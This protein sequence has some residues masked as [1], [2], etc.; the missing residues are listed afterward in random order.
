[1]NKT[2]K[3]IRWLQVAR[4]LTIITLLATSMKMVAATVEYPQVASN[5]PYS[6]VSALRHRS[7]DEKMQYGDDPLQYAL[8][9]KAKSR[10]VDSGKP[11]V[12]LIHG[13]CWLNAFDI[14]HTFPLSTGLTQH[15]YDVWSLEYRRTGDK[16][17]GWPGT[18]NDIKLGVL[19]ATQYTGHENLNNTVVLGHSAGGHLALLAGS[20]IPDLKGV[21]GLAAIADI[22]QYSRGKNS[23][24]SVTKDFMQGTAD[25]KPDAYALANPVQQKPHAKVRLL[26]GEADNIVPPSQALNSGMPSTIIEQAGHFD[27]IHPGSEAFKLLIQTL[28][29]MDTQ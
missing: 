18:F 3:A 11:L 24:Q 27:W 4:S 2:E 29:A 17:G 20:E 26:Q 13:G 10:D 23:C 1:M 16:G 12:I 15:G 22:E 6:S 5:V 28:E 25:T 8:L 9:W 14:E 7:P 21:I 19:A